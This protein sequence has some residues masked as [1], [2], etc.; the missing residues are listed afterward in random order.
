LDEHISSSNTYPS[1]TGIVFPVDV[2]A[3]NYLAKQIAVIYDSD[4]SITDILLGAGAS[5]PS[6]CRQNAVTESVD[7]FGADGRIRHAV[8]IL[9][10]RCTG[11]APEQ[12][13]QLQYQLIRAF[14]RIL[15]LG[16]SQTNDNVFTGNSRPTYQQAL[17]W[18]VMHPIDVICGP[19]TYQCMPNPFTLRDD[20]I[21]G[22]DLLY[23]VGWSVPPGKTSTLARANQVQGNITFPNGQGMQGVNVVV[24]RLEPFWNYP[25]EWESAS[26]V[27]G[28]LF[29]RSSA[30]PVSP[31]IST[32]PT[33]GMGTTVASFEGAFNIYRIPLY[34]W[35]PWQSL[36]IS[37]QPINP[38][39]TG[40]YAV[41][42]YETNAVQPSGS[43]N[44]Q[45]ATVM[46]PFGVY[47]Y[48]NTIDDAAAT[49][50]ISGDGT[51]SAPA[52]APGSGWWTGNLCSYGHSAWTQFTV[53]P[54]RT[55]TLEVTAQDEQR[56]ATT[57][58][59][60]PVIGL[61]NASDPAGIAPSIASAPTAFNSAVNGTTTLTAQ[62]GTGSLLYSLRMAIADQR[63][64]G[65]PDYGYQARILYADSI[66]P[67]SVPSFGGQVTITG[68]G[69]RP[70]NT[71]EVNGVTATVSSW[72]ANTITVV[73]PSLHAT[74]AITAD[75]TVRDLV[76]GSTTTMSGALT[77]AAPQPTLV[78]L[79]AP[80]GQIFT[81]SPA[82]VPFAVQLLQSDGVTP[83]IGAAVGFSFTGAQVRFD[84]CGGSSC[85]LSTDAEGRVSTTVTPLVPGVITLST[86]G[87]GST[88]TASFTAINRLQTLTALNQNLYVATGA[89]I[90]W[91][92]QV[93]ASDNATSVMGVPVQWTGAGA[94]SVSPTMTAVDAG[95][96]AQT[97]ASIG[98]LNANGTASIT[99]CAWATVCAGFSAQGV[100]PDHWGIEIVSG[101]GQ[102][103]VAGTALSPIVLRVVDP[104]GHPIAGALVEVH[105]TLEPW[106]DPC[107]NIGRCPIAP[108][109][110]KTDS[111]LVSAID[112]T[113]TIMPLDLANEALISNIVVVSG[114]QGFVSLVLQRLP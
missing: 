49:C 27:S 103:V 44:I 26:A 48:T 105:Q 14:G 113:V 94:V 37:T 106:S 1:S 43:T 8:L 109:Y 18:P 15:G 24:H 56:Q 28:Y 46:S 64:D 77:Y 21:S 100:A 86:V 39:Y 98:P 29:R 50:D 25:E 38:L 34:D 84:A 57:S 52:L 81:G 22:L 83:I 107:P 42:P 99:A 31:H 4:G 61:W 78:L 91:P 41:G 35:E 92:L 11:P 53:R 6:G 10:G 82:N 79:S 90:N 68:M 76:S 111:T 7:S 45:V 23:P 55:F 3:S 114:T 102:S 62:S 88:V 58:K 20:D 104:M 67:A 71:V 51:E 95:A 73:V 97:I 87:S 70:G 16:W 63:G 89:H 60:L 66:A 59:A 110:G 112:G 101:S 65:R 40:A 32:T 33:S 80:A 5:N 2:Q 54:G 108:I 75:V 9:N 85:T 74:T 72:T 47:Q 17:H 93:M 96:L 13:L 30:N 36:V 12:Q 19:Y 69:F